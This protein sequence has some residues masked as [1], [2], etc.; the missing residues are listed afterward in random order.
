MRNRLAMFILL[1]TMATLLTLGILLTRQTEVI[2][3]AQTNEDEVSV[4]KDKNI[5][6]EE[7]E[8]V[9]EDNKV[10]VGNYLLTG[11]CDCPICQEEWVGTTALGVPPTEEWTIAVDPDYIPLGSMVWIDGFDHAFKAE[12][13]GA[14]IQEK[15][16]D[17]FCS[18]HEECYESIYNRYADVY[19]ITED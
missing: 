9:E 4:I 3:E 1:S 10:Y 13:V 8:L 19:I 14:A 2:L 7:P 11:Y 15:H 5:S 17:V 12:D 18:S 6:V 16:I